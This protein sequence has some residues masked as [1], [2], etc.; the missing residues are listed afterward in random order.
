MIDKLK[1][2]LADFCTVRSCVTLMFCFTACVLSIMGRVEPAAIVRFV[3][4]LLMFWFGTKAHS[5]AEKI[6]EK[7]KK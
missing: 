6:A 2:N 5:I 7:M 1:E 3:E 4:M